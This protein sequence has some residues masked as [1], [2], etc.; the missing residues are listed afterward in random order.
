L[1]SEFERYLQQLS[2]F[3]AITLTFNGRPITF[4]P[5]DFG[6]L[7]DNNNNNGTILFLVPNVGSTPIIRVHMNDMN[8]TLANAYSQMPNYRTSDGGR[9]LWW[10]SRDNTC[11][12]IS[13]ET[14]M[15]V[16]MRSPWLQMK[17]TNVKSDTM[18]I[19]R[20]TTNPNSDIGYLTYGG[21][22]LGRI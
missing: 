8:Q 12:Q 11:Y 5:Y 9:W 14:Q 15:R 22:P 20:F 6:S 7:W 19:E 1:R 16:Y 3:N 10:E 21:S 18:E 17:L 4:Y 2:E 13:V